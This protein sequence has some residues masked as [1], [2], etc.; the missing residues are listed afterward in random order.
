MSTTTTLARWGKLPVAISRSGL[1]R[2]TLYEMAEQYP[3]LFRKHGAA[4]IVD[5]ELL[6]QILASL[7]S[8]NIGAT[9]VAGDD[10]A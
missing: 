5:L 4:T 7:P 3:D 2:S 9:K 6:D 8:A 10:A 1:S